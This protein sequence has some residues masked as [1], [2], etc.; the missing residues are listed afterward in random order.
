MEFTQDELNLIAIYNAGNREK[1]IEE[2][3]G[4]HSYL[5]DD[6]KELIDLIT[7]VLNKLKAISDEKYESLYLYPDFDDWF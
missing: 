7:N 6:E 5:D 4:I 3:V 2:I 1:T